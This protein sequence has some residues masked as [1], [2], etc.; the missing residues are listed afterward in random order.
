MRYGALKLARQYHY[1]GNAIKTL[2]W[3]QKMGYSAEFS[4]SEYVFL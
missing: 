3:L 4:I 2:L 1:I